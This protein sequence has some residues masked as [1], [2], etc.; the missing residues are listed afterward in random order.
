MKKIFLLISLIIF[1]VIAKAQTVP[2]PITQNVA[3][4]AS[5]LLATNTIKADQGII[6]GIFTDTTAANALPYLK[7]Y[8]GVIIFCTSDSSAYQ[9]FVGATTAFWF[10]IAGGSMGPTGNFWAPNGNSFPFAPSNPSYNYGIGVLDNFGLQFLTNATA[11]LIIPNNGI[12]RSSGAEN[13]CLSYDTITHKLY[14][15]D[16][17]GAGGTPGIDDVLA[18]GQALTANRSINLNGGNQF[19]LYDGSYYA[20]YDGYDYLMRLRPGHKFDVQIPDVDLTEMKVDDD[21]ILAYTESI[22]EG[23]TAKL[24]ANQD[25]VEAAVSAPYPGGN[26]QASARADYTSGTNSLSAGIVV[27]PVSSINYGFFVDRNT[28]MEYMGIATGINNNFFKGIR[29]DSTKRVE[30]D[31][32][33]HSPRTDLSVVLWDSVGKKTYSTPMSAFGSGS[34]TVT[35]V[36]SGNGM[37]FSTITGTGAVTMG[38]PSSITLSS[39]NSLTSTSHTHAFAPGGTTSQY[40]KG[41][42]SLGSS[43]PSALIPT[44]QQ[45]TTAGNTTTNDMVYNTSGGNTS[46][47]NDAGT[48]LIEITET[49]G[50]TRILDL[51]GHFIQFSDGAHNKQI[52]PG[53][54]GTNRIFTLPDSSGTLPLRVKVSGTTYNPAANG[55]IDL[56]TI[57]GGITVGTT[58][59]TSGTDKRFAY[60]NA[61]VY[62][63]TSG[64]GYGNTDNLVNITSP[65]TTNIPLAIEGTYFG[66]A[67]L[68]EIRDK[69]NHAVIVFVNSGG[70]IRTLQNVSAFYGQAEQ[71]VIGYNATGASAGISFGASSDADIYRSAAA[72]LK[73]DVATFIHSGNVTITGLAG[74][75]SRAVLADA[76]G[77]LSAPISD[78]K[79]KREIIP[80]TNGLSLIMQLNP[81]SFFYKK[82]FQNFGTRQQV[83]FI[84]QDI[85]KVMPN[86]VFENESGKTKGLL[87]YSET[88]IIPLLVQAVQTQQKQ[89]DVLTK[90]IKKLKRK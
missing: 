62:G 87:G 64:V 17:S 10:K 69:S 71:V 37:N 28:H 18:V 6:P 31:T 24:R 54:F 32:I 45:V 1:S 63:E 72:T 77:V 75:G 7:Y 46:I 59:I 73:A 48:P 16:C 74:T 5:T 30:I 53:T 50:S 79:A 27:H 4:T 9:R 57:G 90:E 78:K 15:C 83:G 70:A 61:G 19:K 13:K 12:V 40:I 56:G 23:T 52:I 35:S 85:Q 26:D 11:R 14:Y 76:S 2:Y 68:F 21:E 47:T 33:Y 58:T 86:S 88:D 44:L 65:S 43:L 89:I 81:V 49:G 67:N 8:N 25:L 82:E 51:E 55:T 36:S 41:D 22:S 38:T 34:G 80:I 60:N 29:I 66:T 84:A 3:K 42:G 20:S 39:T